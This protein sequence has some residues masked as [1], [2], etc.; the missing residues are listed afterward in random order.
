MRGRP[1]RLLAVAL[2]VPSKPLD[3]HLRGPAAHSGGLTA[4]CRVAGRTST[5]R[6]ARPPKHWVRRI[7]GAQGK[8]WLRRRRVEAGSP[9]AL[10]WMCA[11]PAV[12]ERGGHLRSPTRWGTCPASRDAGWDRLAQCG[13]SLVGT[14]TA[15]TAA[16]AHESMK[17]GPVMRDSMP[18]IPENSDGDTS[19]E[20]P[21]RCAPRLLM[22]RTPRAFPRAE[23]LAR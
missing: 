1:R 20:T 7:V 10:A 17:C 13:P 16:D 21:N 3:S 12:C 14:D 6:G 4:P 11:S 19:G 5:S 18:G 8:A 2:R 22:L 15:C 9:S 23:G